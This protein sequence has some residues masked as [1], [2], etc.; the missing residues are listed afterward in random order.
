MCKTM[1]TIA[2]HI[3]QTYWL[4]PP[5]YWV[6]I[7][8]LLILFRD[9]HGKTK[10]QTSNES[11]EIITPKPIEDKILKNLDVLKKLGR[12]MEVSYS[13]RFPIRFRKPI[14]IL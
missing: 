1:A 14:T 2:W 8:T 7:K 9:K 6:K 13:Q 11:K 4:K 3:S 12:K 10:E 5:L